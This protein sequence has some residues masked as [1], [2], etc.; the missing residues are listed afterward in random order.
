MRGRARG[1]EIGSIIRRGPQLSTPRKFHLERTRGGL[2][3]GM[4]RALGLRPAWCLPLVDTVGQWARMSSR[5]AADAWASVEADA[6]YRDARKTSRKR[7]F[8]RRKAD[9]SMGKER[10]RSEYQRMRREDIERK[11]LGRR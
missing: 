11:G 10:P 4:L 9:Q 2:A 3:R 8:R 5:K 7:A 6:V 1:N